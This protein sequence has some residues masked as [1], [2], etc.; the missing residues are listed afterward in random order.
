MVKSPSKLV[1]MEHRGVAETARLRLQPRKNGKAKRRRWLSATP[2]LPGWRAR[3]TRCWQSSDSVRRPATTISAVAALAIYDFKR[4]TVGRDHARLIPFIRSFVHKFLFRS[5]LRC[6]PVEHLPLAAEA[7]RN[8]QPSRDRLINH[9]LPCFFVVLPT[10]PIMCFHL[11]LLWWCS[12]PGRR[13]CVGPQRLPCALH[14]GKSPTLIV[15]V[16]GIII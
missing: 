12:R 9:L 13:P 8:K 11:W 10:G 3:S 15:I 2:K 14:T 16:I 5:L 6:A 1:G 4:Q 7:N